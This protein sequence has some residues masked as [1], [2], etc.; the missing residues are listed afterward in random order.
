VYI[1]NLLA[2]AIFIPLYKLIPIKSMINPRIKI[3][4][5]DSIDK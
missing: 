1:N 4:I 5:A 3:I 2:D